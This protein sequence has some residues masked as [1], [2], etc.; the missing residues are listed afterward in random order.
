M[1]KTENEEGE[2]LSLIE[3][4][5]KKGKFR[6][7]E[8]GRREGGVNKKWLVLVLVSTIIVSLGFYLF[9]GKEVEWKTK[10]K[11]GVTEKV[12]KQTEE[13][14]FGPKIYEF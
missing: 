3:N 13:G 5:N 12:N 10:T 6:G 4:Q 11:A 14:V 1:G 8:G 2:Q 7:S 9:S